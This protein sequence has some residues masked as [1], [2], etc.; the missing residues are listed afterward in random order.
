MHPQLEIQRNSYQ[1]HAVN[2]NDEV[3]IMM[4]VQVQGTVIKA[5]V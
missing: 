5:S 3:V 1:S 2:N 4:K